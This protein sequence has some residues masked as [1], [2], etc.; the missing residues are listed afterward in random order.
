[1]TQFQSV[2]MWLAASSV[3][4]RDSYPA[5]YLG[6]MPSPGGTPVVEADW[7]G[8][9][10]VALPTG[11]SVSPGW[12]WNSGAATKQ[13]LELNSWYFLDSGR[14][15]SWGTKWSL[16]PTVTFSSGSYSAFVVEFFP[17]IASW[18]AA[19]CYVSLETRFWHS[20]SATWGLR[21]NTSLPSAVVTTLSSW[22]PIRT[23]PLVGAV[24]FGQVEFRALDPNEPLIVRLTVR[25]S[26]W[27]A[28][29]AAIGVNA[30][31]SAPLTVSIP[32]LKARIWDGE[33]LHVYVPR[34]PVFVDPPFPPWPS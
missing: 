28:G 7:T 8:P 13:D 18:S 34:E 30:F 32:P 1:V 14:I 6:T 11:F 12:G 29:F 4:Y 21:S 25:F 16:S 27:L 22:K 15:P 19:L 9:K 31:E 33:P 26:A 3:Q 5:N 10:G 24:P 17:S 23:R 20:P 2:D